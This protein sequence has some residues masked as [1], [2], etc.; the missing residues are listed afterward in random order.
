MF[1]SQIVEIC[2]RNGVD[3]TSAVESIL[4]H[5]TLAHRGGFS[6]TPPGFRPSDWYPWRF[7]RRLSLISR[8]IIRLS[9]EADSPWILSPGLFGDALQVIF[10][11]YYRG[12]VHP[13]DAQSPAMKAWLSGESSR[14]AH[15]HVLNVARTLEGIGLN[16]VVEK[17]LSELLREKADDRLGDVDVLAWRKQT[18]I[19]YAIEC[20]DLLFAKTA[21]EIAEQLRRFSGQVGSRGEKDDLLKH[22][23]RCSEL[24]K[25]S[26]ALAT[27]LSETTALVVKCV[28]CFSSPVAIK[29][30]QSRFPSVLF[31]VLDDIAPG[32][33]FFD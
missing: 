3:N 31:I 1:R 18:G 13:D 15:A 6:V 16:T 17:G 20:K 4:E 10:S 19:V 32:R 29:Y 26:R 33:H 2:K 5:F 27:N 22:L 12:E 25:R 28:V 21:T 24:Q 14:R 7:R 8:P 11:R 30:V 23:E 9:N